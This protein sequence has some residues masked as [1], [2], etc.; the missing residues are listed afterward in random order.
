MRR[1]GQKLPKEEIRAGG[2]RGWLTFMKMPAGQPVWTA[3]LTGPNG[4]NVLPEL[5]SATVTGISDG[6]LISGHVE[7]RGEPLPVR[8]TWYCKPTE[9]PE[10]WTSDERPNDGRPK[11]GR[12]G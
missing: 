1:N 3:K 7:R 12:R 10:G 11:P 6:I 2:K 5:M 9:P 8:Q 4:G